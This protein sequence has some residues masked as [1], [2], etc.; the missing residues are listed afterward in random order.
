MHT[1]SIT[2]LERLRQP[3]DPEAWCHFVELYTP[4]LY[5][6]SRRLGLQEADAAVQLLKC[7]FQPSAKGG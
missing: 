4:L 1:T 5:S 3:S 2:L 6:W 7:N